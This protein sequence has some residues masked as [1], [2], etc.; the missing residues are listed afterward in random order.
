[1]LTRARVW[2]SGRRI[3]IIHIGVATATHRGRIA[4]HADGVAAV[5]VAVLVVSIRIP[6]RI[7]RIQGSLRICTASTD[8]ESLGSGI[9][10]RRINVYGIPADWVSISR[11]TVDTV[12]DGIVSVAA[13][14]TVAARVSVATWVSITNRVSVSTR[15]TGVPII[16]RISTARWEPIYRIAIVTWTVPIDVWRGVSG[17]VGVDA[18]ARGVSVVGV[19][20][21]WVAVARCVSVRVVGAGRVPVVG[22]VPVRAPAVP[23]VVV[24]VVIRVAVAVSALWVSVSITT[25]TTS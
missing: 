6:T 15:E 23:V 10:V 5:R 11:I 18:D 9:S 24:A 22:G 4:V 17:R 8:G 16:D 20:V 12:G 14:I 3:F 25:S 2:W 19:S 7:P 1:M 21:Y 13:R